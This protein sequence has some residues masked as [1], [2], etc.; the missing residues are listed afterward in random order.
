M[1]TKTIRQVA[2]FKVPPHEVYEALMDS[3]KYAK[4]T[5][6]KANISRKVGGKVSAYDG[7]IKAINVELVPDKIIVQRWRGDDWP[8]DHYSVAKFILRKS[9]SGTKLI[10]T[11]TG[12]PEDVYVDI[13]DGWVAYYWQKME[14]IFSSQK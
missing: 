3:K 2:N 5:G 7:W 13:K 14:K 4:F 1:K 12:V 8:K 11:Q 10:F 9:K 6:S